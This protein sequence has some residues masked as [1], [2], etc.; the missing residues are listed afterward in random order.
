MTGCASGRFDF[1]A[2]P[3]VAARP[4]ELKLQ[5]FTKFAR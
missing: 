4:I 3:P 1:R 5:Q 2:I